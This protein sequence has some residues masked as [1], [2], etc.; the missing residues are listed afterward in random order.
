MF[1]QT[2]LVNITDYG[3]QVKY[4]T[5]FTD[6]Q[7]HMNIKMIWHVTY[8]ITCL[9]LVHTESDMFHDIVNVRLRADIQMSTEFYLYIHVIGVE[10][11]VHYFL[12]DCTETTK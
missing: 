8:N 6:S 12:F 9:T 5:I 10:K 1:T 3:F 4:L 7:Q 2:K 11:K